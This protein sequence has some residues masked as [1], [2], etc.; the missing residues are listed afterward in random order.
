MNCYV[1]SAPK[2]FRTSPMIAK[3]LYSGGGRIMDDCQSSG[4]RR[5]LQMILPLTPISALFDVDAIVAIGC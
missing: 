4:G 5:W 3:V 1:A 2:D